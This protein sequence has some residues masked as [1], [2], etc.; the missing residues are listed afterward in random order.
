MR[1]LELRQLEDLRIAQIIDANLDRAREGLRVLEDWARFALGRKD[2]VKSFK[3]CRQI[4]G[5]NHLKVYKESRNFTYDKCAGLSHPEQFKRNS[6]NCII[7]SNAARV[8]EA[9]RVI[10][11]F[12]RD[13]N[14]NL[15]NISSKIRYEI[16]NLEI[17][18]LESKS[19]SSLL[20]ILDENDLYFITLDNENLFEKVKNILEGGVKIIQLRCKQ[21]R[22]SDNLKFAIKLR[23]LCSDFGALFLIND[24]VDIALACKADGIHLGQGDIDI[25]SAR[26]ILGYSKIIGISASNE[27]EINKA[28]QDGCD[29]LGIGPVF[30][31]TTKKEKVPLGIDTLKSLTKNISI[32]WFAIGG[33]K[34]ENI[35]LLKENNICKVA[36]IKDLI[37][38]KNP[39]EKAIMMINSLNDEN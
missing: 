18:L 25:K 35:S 32:P 38:S 30:A 20:R 28:I 4:L 22:D 16:Y 39:K 14:Q 31:T 10:E 37:N 26:K 21:G 9:L 1:N 6:T 24:R 3:N 15:C 13:H 17:A 12:S 7:S 11:E 27:Y 5:K 19:N 33:I 23:E 8:Q 2:L 34:Q 29:Y 36:V